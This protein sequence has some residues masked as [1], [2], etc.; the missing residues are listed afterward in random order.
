MAY[1]FFS[2]GAESCRQCWRNLWHGAMY[3][4]EKNGERKTFAKELFSFRV[5]EWHLIVN[6]CVCAVC[7]RNP[8]TIRDCNY[9][10]IKLADKSPAIKIELDGT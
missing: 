4:R 3:T 10:I 6:R 2:F 7:A 9:Y 5:F 1:N 8:R